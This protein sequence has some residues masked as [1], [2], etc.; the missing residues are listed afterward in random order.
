MHAGKVRS[1]FLLSIDILLGL[2]TRFVFVLL[3]G[4]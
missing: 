1:C 3:M 2:R 4:D